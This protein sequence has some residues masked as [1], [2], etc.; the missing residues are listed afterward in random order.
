M[1]ALILVGGYGTRLRPLTLSYPKP[2]VEFCNKPMLLHQI[3]ALVEVN[4]KEII[5]AVSKCADKEDL[6]EAELKHHEKRLGITV[7]F[8]YET[9]PLGTA[10]PLALARK[11]LADTDEPFFVLNSDVVCNFPF[12]NLLSFHLKS[13]GEAT[14]LLTQ[15]VEPSKFGVIV[16]DDNTGLVKAFIEKPQDFVGNKINA[17]LY[18]L[19]PSIIDRIPLKPTS[20]EQ[21]I[22]PQLVL[23]GKLFC[24]PL[25]GF[26]M[27][28]GQPKDFI[29]GT[30]LYL[31]H[32]ATLDCSG[33]SSGPNFIGNNLVDPT[34][35]IAP[36]S[37]IG[38]NVVIGPGVVVE[39]GV[40][41][42]DS[43]LLRG[44]ILKAH[45]WLNKC[46]IGWNCQ[47][48]KWVRMENV[49]VLGEDV[50]VSD[51]MY[52]NGGRVLPHKTIK[53][54]VTEPQIIM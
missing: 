36:S 28:V 3:E 25:S 5:L 23:E 45:S 34:A 12:E 51:E 47:V 26:W 42:S 13:K 46:I 17:G 39:D 15:V 32:L 49:S 38:P 6:M 41:I 30:S 18:I 8:S 54:C 33:L 43:T 44:C 52:V 40:R 2:I 7:H 24:L 48:G 31:E 9:E 4:V 53:E 10:G 21:K 19:N 16:Y 37:V 29:T 14:I 20:I 11:W 50:V 27:D 35:K 1:K 22:F